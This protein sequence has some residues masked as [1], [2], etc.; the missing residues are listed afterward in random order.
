MT[1]EE[2]EKRL[3]ELDDI[4]SKLMALRQQE[5]LLLGYPVTKY[6]PVKKRAFTLYPS[7]EKVYLNERI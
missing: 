7:G 6:D 2:E 1:D 4:F 5:D 3:D